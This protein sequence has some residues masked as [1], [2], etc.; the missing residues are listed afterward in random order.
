ME[1]RFNR[2]EGLRERYEAGINEYFQLQ[3]I[4][5]APLP[6]NSYIEVDSKGNTIVKACVLPHHAVIK[7][8][9]L[10]TKTRIVFNA[11]SKTSNGRSLN[12]NLST[13]PKLQ[14]ELP[15]VILNWR[16][17]EFVFT[18]DIQ[19][20][21]RC[22]DM[23]PD[24]IQYQQ[25]LWRN[26]SGELQSYC[27]NTVAFG[28][29]P[30][31]CLAIRVVHQ[32]AE[33][34]RI[35]YPLAEHILKAE[36]YVDDVQSGGDSLENALQ[37]RDHLIAALRSAGMELRKW[38]SNHPSLLAS[39]P[40]EH[41]SIDSSLEFKSTEIVKTLGMSWQPTTDQFKFKI[42]FELPTIATKRAV[43]SVTARLFDPLGY[44]A[45]VI[46]VAKIIL[47]G[48]WSHL[49]LNND[50]LNW[51]DS[52]PDP[53]N[54]CW[55]KFLKELPDIE[56]L[57]IPRWVDFSPNRIQ[58]AELHA[59]C[60]GSSAAYA[61][62]VYI[63]LQSATGKIHTH[64]IT[65][66]TK[67][68]PTKPLTI[69][70]IEL[71]GAELLP[72]LAVWAKKVL[73]EE[74]KD[75]PI[76]FWSDATIV[77][78]WLHGDVTRWKTFV[79]NR[80]SKI[81][82]NSS[83]QQWSHVRTHENPADCATRGLTPSQL[84][85]FELW[86]KGPTWLLG[87]RK[88]WP[89][90]S[91]NAV[92][93]DDDI[94]EVKPSSVYVHVSIKSD[95]IVFLYSSLFKLI[96]INAWIRRFRHNVI[97]KV[98]KLHGPLTV[99]ECQESLIPLICLVQTGAFGK[100]IK[101]ILSTEPLPS[102]CKISGLAPFLD[103]HNILRVRGRLQRS[104]LPYR[105]RHPIILPHNHHFTNL[106]ID[107]A[108]SNT[109][110]GG[111]QIT[112]TNIR[113]LYWIVN[114]R[115]AVQSRIRKC[116]TCFKAKPEIVNQIMGNLPYNRVNPPNRPFI[117]TGVDYTG[118]VELKASKFRGNTTYKVYIVIF[119]CL[120]SKAVNLEASTG[121]TTEHF[122][123]ALHRFIGRRGK[124]CHMHSDNGTNFVGAEKIV[125]HNSFVD[126]INQDIV[127]KLSIQGIEWHFNPPHSPNF[128][129]LWE[130]NI[131]SLKFHLK[132]VIDS[133]KLTFEELTTVLV[134]IESCLNSRPLCPLTAD[135]D[136]LDVLTPGHFLIG[137]AL[138]APPENPSKAMSLSTQY[139]ALQ[140]M[141][142]QFWVKWSGDWLSHLQARPKWHTEREN[143]QTNDLVIIKDDRL[144]PN[145]WILG[146][147]TE[148]H[149]GADELIRVATIRTKN[150]SYKR[151]ISKLCRLPISTYTEEI[152]Q[153]A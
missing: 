89:K 100:E 15:A 16:F 53:L 99:A 102:K 95:S 33:D 63:R 123:C 74:F 86:W 145:E 24:D 3:Q 36:M 66:K 5:P 111:A 10:T 42:K 23:H 117:A 69:P 127:P 98:N 126:A 11:A 108:H 54:E 87:S 110:H 109:L 61:A 119:I 135:P 141:I 82:S 83:P 51:D 68:A 48:I 65:A 101:C 9:S 142:H 75:I 55:K 52:I 140:Q 112:L 21:Y 81:L 60:D 113:G 120:A 62:T 121:M 40:V 67:V 125:G 13:G 58:S 79:A 114:G 4:V 34:E 71:C 115:R 104:S 31:P 130:A 25:I 116:V 35:N 37:K 64:L 136:D 73:P 149:P 152:T 90:F 45:P 96:R 92:K 20:M 94:A 151:S 77:L 153:Q 137:D 59:F 124:P 46:I 129:G 14:N 28:T 49:S 76:Y 139:I 93:F 43:L 50:I 132:R 118:A 18:A 91:S 57:S 134:R 7:E 41:Q 56:N 78:H 26:A 12:D 19:R 138:L 105:Q 146:R 147:I 27:L 150:G 22:I 29:S 44:I 133:T 30:A 70:R 97:N 144:P 17:Y 103:E 131:K 2:V 85:N 32:I 72:R 80:V 6:E 39:I 106:V 84:A 148:L 128:G 88:N 47:K 107:N 122:L 8:D 38:C 143:L 1:R